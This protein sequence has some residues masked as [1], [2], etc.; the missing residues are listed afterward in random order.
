MCTPIPLTTF[1]HPWTLTYFLSF[2]LSCILFH[3]SLFQVSW[4]FFTH[5]FFFS[6]LYPF[7]ASHSAFLTLLKFVPTD[8][9]WS[10]MNLDKISLFLS[11]TL[12]FSLRQRQAVMLATTHIVIDLDHN[13]KLINGGSNHPN[14]CCFIWLLRIVPFFLIMYFAFSLLL[15]FHLSC[16]MKTSICLFNAHFN[17]IV[18]ISNVDK[19][20]ASP[21]IYWYSMAGK[22][23]I[24]KE[25]LYQGFHLIIH[26]SNHLPKWHHLACRH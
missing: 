26:H 14:V 24:C 6:S 3:F 23:R 5:S 9:I 22:N 15:Y 21:T 11:L 4:V 17:A 7:C 18:M 12:K 20:L 2:F 25:I 19:I 1:G 10:H 8:L 13:F 16:I